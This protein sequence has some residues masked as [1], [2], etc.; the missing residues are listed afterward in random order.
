VAS[1]T[2]RF[3]V[4]DVLADEMFARLGTSRP[5]TDAD[6]ADLHRRWVAAIPFDSVAKAAAVAEGHRPPGGDATGFCEQWL[7]DGLGGTCWGHVA[8]LGGLL[9]AAGVD[10][11][12]GVER[13][14]RP[15]RVD[16]H[17]FL[18]VETACGPHTVDTAHPGAGPLQRTDGARSDHPVYLTGHTQAD[19]GRLQHWFATPAGNVPSGRYNPVSDDLD[20][21]DV[22]AFC[23]V[24]ATHSGV[25]ARSLTHKR[26][27]AD[28]LV[29][30]GPDDNGRCLA[31]RSWSAH[32][33]EVTRLPAAEPDALF[34]ALGYSPAVRRLAERGGL[35][36]NGPGGPTLATGAL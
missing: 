15:D 25:R 24:S 18:V 33:L 2:A 6:V 31:V 12:I 8:G 32:G 1:R 9:A 19:D 28:T 4:D 17:G 23:E 11:R 35:L 36:T 13:M 14:V 29:Q 3:A 21:G 26:V 34:A 30:A 16:F 5:A 7:A 10:Y 27:T 22:E 20:V